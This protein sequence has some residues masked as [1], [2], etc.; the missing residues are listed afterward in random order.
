MLRVE[1]P[2]LFVSEQGLESMTDQSMV[3]VKLPVLADPTLVTLPESPLTDLHLEIF[4]YTLS[5]LLPLTLKLTDSFSKHGH[6][7]WLMIR[8]YQLMAVVMMVEVPTSANE[9]VF[10]RQFV[11]YAKFDVLKAE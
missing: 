8:T 11:R 6:F 2:S 1:E 7:V 5:V 10:R 3:E 4:T 9:I